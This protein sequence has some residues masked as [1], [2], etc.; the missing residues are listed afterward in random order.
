MTPLAE[1]SRAVTPLAEGSRGVT[2]LVAMTIAGSDSGA[3]AGLQADLKTMG[4]LGVFA[5]TVVTSVTAQNTAR[6]AAVHRV[7]ADFVRLQIETVLA[8]LPVAAVKTGLLG[9]ADVVRTIGDLAAQGLL[10][11]LVVDPVMVSSSGQPLL[12]PGGVQAYREVLLPHAQLVTPNLG[13]T[14]LLCG[15]ARSDLTDVPSM[16]EAARAI[17]A[18]GPAWVLVK[19]GHLP[20]VESEG[21]PSTMVPDVLYGNGTVTVMEHSWVATPNT[22]GTGCTLSAAVTAHLATGAGMRQAVDAARQF[23]HRALTGSAAWRIGR[24]HGPLD[25]LGW[26]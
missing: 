1:G 24:G 26:S 12:D 11:N 5:T 23:V 4:A 7:P 8:D 9:T 2:P 21:P 15:I 3:G 22:H 17:A 13:E 19:G 20:G 14:A 18:G 25:Q 10:P 6:V 16:S